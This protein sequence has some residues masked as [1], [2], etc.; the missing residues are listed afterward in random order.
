M[1]ISKTTQYAFL[2][3][4]FLLVSMAIAGFTFFY[5]SMEGAKLEE[6]M[7]VVGKNRLMQDRYN[8]LLKI[9]EDT[10]TEHEQLGGHL[11]TEGNTINFLSEIESLARDMGLRFTTDSL[12]V[13]AL[14]NPQF[15]AI[16]LKLR[17]DGDRETLVSFL[18]IL[19]S[20]PYFSRINELGL[21]AAGGEDLWSAKITLMVGMQAHDK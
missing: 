8:N 14:P 19:E 3:L 6:Q 5:V 7:E 17:A 13:E 18:N 21:E 9:L 15:E 12:D 1:I 11:L 2:S 16:N 20:L 10:K 4:A